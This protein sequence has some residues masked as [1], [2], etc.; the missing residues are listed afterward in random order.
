MTRLV[1]LGALLA[2][3]V[4]L[5]A[6][7]SAFAQAEIAIASLD[8][9]GD[10]EEVVIENSGDAAQDL[11][12]WT[13]ESDGEG[14]PEEFDLASLGS[15]QPGATVF[16]RSGPGATGV[17]TWSETFIF[18]DGDSTDYVRILDDTG[19]T[20]DEVNC[21]PGSGATPTAEPTPEATVEPAPANDVPNGGGAPAGGGGG[22]ASSTTVGIGALLAALGFLSVTLS[23]L[24]ARI[25]GGGSI[26]A[27]AEAP[28]A[29][30]RRSAAAPRRAPEQTLGR[31]ILGLATI[32]LL[33][34]LI[35]RS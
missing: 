17:F 9:D 30:A 24:G 26:G 18:R 29:P 2:T 10:P 16:I 3:A 15:L 7:S 33:L 14:E 31:V 12:G 19:A 8:C 13:L 20:V 21:A 1:V 5:V 32:A 28:E 11:S 6:V 25:T 4:A 27:P 34:F 23:R 35:R 22:I